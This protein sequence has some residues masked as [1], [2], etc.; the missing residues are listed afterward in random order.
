MK[1]PWVRAAVLALSL[2]VLPLPAEAAKIVVDPGHGGMDSGAVGINGLMEKTVNLDIAQKLRD[3]L[4]QRGY[5]VVMTRQSDVYWSLKERV[6]Y[7][8]VQDADL[9]VSVHANSYSN[10]NTRGSMVLYYDDASPQES[11]PASERMKALTPQSRELAQKVLDAFVR[12]TGLPNQGLTQS[13]VYVVRMGSIP[14]ILVETAFLSNKT[15]A[16]LLANSDER[17]LM[18]GAIAEG[19]EAYLPPDELFP[20][21]RGHWAREA[22]LRLQAQHVVEGTGSHFEPNRMLTRAEWVTLLGRVFDLPAGAAGSCGAPGTVG[23]AV[24]GGGCGSGAA[25]GLSAFR[26]VNAG[27]WAFAALEKAVKAGVLEGYPDGTLRP[28]RP[29]TR[30]EAAALLQ[31]LAEAPQAPAGRQPFQDVPA[32]Y[33]AAQAIAGLQAAGWVDGVT[34]EQFRPERSITRAEAAALIDRYVQSAPKKPKNQP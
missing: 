33:W 27:H 34:A 13:A 32:G 1:K 26:D 29:V 7:T 14:S 30:A 24:Y 4:V 20:D 17:T 5:E 2:F 11:Y 12:K 18:A 10:P 15:D 31:R 6:D 3:A 19:I 9:F 22:V 28:D 16:A 25:G 8:D 23:G 21:L